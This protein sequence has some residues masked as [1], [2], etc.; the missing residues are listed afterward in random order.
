[1]SR[2]TLTKLNPWWTGTIPKN[3][4]NLKGFLNLTGY[5]HK[6]VQNYGRI[7]TPLTT[8]LKK[9]AFSWTPDETQAFEQHKEVM[10]KYHVLTTP[11]F[12]KTYIVEC[13]TSRN[14]INVVLMQDGRPLAFESRPI[15]GKNL[16]KP[17]YD[18]E[19]LAILH[20]IK[21]WHPYLIG[22]HFKVKT[23]HASLK[24]F[25]KHRLST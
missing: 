16:R 4:N 21:Q 12:T 25:L 1:M 11:E 17:I 13:D 3:L 10:C 20:A 2:Y 23:I 14:G 24:Y 9:E 5:C 22:S 18:K 7:A 15:K 8:L 19:M 6:F